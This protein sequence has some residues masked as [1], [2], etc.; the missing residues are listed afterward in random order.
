MNANFSKTE[1]E[2]AA[3]TSQTAPGIQ[4]LQEFSFSRFSDA[5]FLEFGQEFS[6]SLAPH[7]GEKS[8]TV[9]VNRLHKFIFLCCGKTLNL[10]LNSLQPLVR[11]HSPVVATPFHPINLTFT[12]KHFKRSSNQTQINAFRE[13]GFRLFAGRDDPANLVSA[14]NN[15]KLAAEGHHPDGQLLYGLCLQEGWGVPIGLVY[16]GSIISSQPIKVNILLN[17]IMASVTREVEVFRLIWFWLRSII[18][19]RPSKITP[20]VSSSMASV[21]NSVEVVHVIRYWV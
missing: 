19:W 13:D 1:K 10:H 14:A 17:T 6:L 5:F 21:L 2:V 15:F 20:I 9:R 7:F 18:N 11:P 12:A 3:E 4:N 8:K 16:L